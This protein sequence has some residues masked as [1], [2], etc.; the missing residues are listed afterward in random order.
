MPPEGGLVFPETAV[1]SLDEEITFTAMP[2][3]GWI[4]R[5]W[6][7]SPGIEWIHR[8]ESY[9]RR[10]G[11]NF[12]TTA[13]FIEVPI[14]DQ[15][16]IIEVTN[17][18]TGRIWMDRNMGAKR[19]ANSSMDFEA[20]G[21]LYQWGRGSDG[22]EIWSSIAVPD[23]SS[24][25]EPTHSYFILSYPTVN[26]DWRIPENNE[27]WKG[28]DGINNP[29]P[30]GFSVP[31]YEEWR[32]EIETWPKDK[33]GAQ[34]A[35]EST[36]K[37]PSTGLRRYEDGKVASIAKNDGFYWSSSLFHDNEGPRYMWFHDSILNVSLF[38]SVGT[39]LTY[40]ANGLAVRCIKDE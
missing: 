39:G 8:T 24:V 16:E 5:E 3:R 11:R 4:F 12:T 23:L 19:V 27:L 30:A 10:I 15:T 25:D 7:E 18:Q 6:K 33:K 35:F 14:V 20:M 40:R 9:S 17:P 2:N 34:V 29:C 22:H 32:E 31:T 21:Y 37:L 28:S 1:Y 38:K 26:N 36:L 13:Y